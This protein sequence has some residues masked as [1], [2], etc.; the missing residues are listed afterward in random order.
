MLSSL[1]ELARAGLAFAET[2]ARLAAADVEE[3]AVRFIEIAVL[4]AVALFFFAAFVIFASIT[5]LLVMPDRLVGAIVIAVLY[6]GAGVVVTL[7]VR[8]RLRERP[9]FLAATLEELRKDRERLE[10]KS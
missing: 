3:Q 7:Y 2:R 9:A 1:K 4:A 5:V 10:T 6:L 8:G